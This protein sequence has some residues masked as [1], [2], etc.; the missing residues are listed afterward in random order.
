MTTAKPPHVALR[1]SVIGCVPQPDGFH[2]MKLLVI[3]NDRLAF[4]FQMVLKQTLHGP[5]SYAGEGC[6]F[7]KLTV[8]RTNSAGKSMDSHDMN[9]FVNGDS[10]ADVCETIANRLATTKPVSE[11]VAFLTIRGGADPR[12]HFRSKTLDEMYEHAEAL[13]ELHST[14]LEVVTTFSVVQEPIFEVKT[15]EQ[16]AA[17]TTAPERA[18][19]CLPSREL[20]PHEFAVLCHYQSA[21]VEAL[22]AKYSAA[23]KKAYARSG[24][25]HIDV[26]DKHTAVMYHMKSNPVI[27]EPEHAAALLDQGFEVK[28]IVNSVT[29]G[30]TM[31]NDLISI[32]NHYYLYL[33]TSPAA[34]L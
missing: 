24:K 3:D 11:V 29:N 12:Q 25:L 23:L 30:E 17:K 32:P 6:R 14:P 4:Q 8:I 5:Y 22:T 7:E 13:L 16:A 28:A 21:A 31:N 15:V 27:L 18:P 9:L 2:D 19:L 26:T 33:V 10:Y 34:L 20:T 1:L